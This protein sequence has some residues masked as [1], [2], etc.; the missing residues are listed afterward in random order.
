[1]E[2]KQRRPE[3]PKCRHCGVELG[4]DHKP[5]CPSVS[6]ETMRRLEI[7]ARHVGLNPAQPCLRCGEL[8]HGFMAATGKPICAGCYASDPRVKPHLRPVGF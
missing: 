4:E 2:D 5:T 1:M 6:A 3:F 8:T 7:P